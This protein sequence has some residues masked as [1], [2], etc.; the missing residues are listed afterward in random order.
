MRV[1]PLL[2]LCSFTSSPPAWSGSKKSPDL[3]KQDIVASGS[4]VPGV[5]RMNKEAE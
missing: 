5:T 2:V 3:Y 1:V 4:G